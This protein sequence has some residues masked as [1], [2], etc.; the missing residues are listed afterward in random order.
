ML[1]DDFWENIDEKRKQN[2][3]ANTLSTKVEDT[4]GLL[5][6]ICIP[7]SEWMEEARIEWKLD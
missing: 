6:A 7:Q 5:C 1:G 2:M 4:E 3:V